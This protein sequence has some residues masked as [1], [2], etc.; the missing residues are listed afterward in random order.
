M[1]VVAYSQ[2]K[3]AA[4]TQLSD[5]DTI[6][7]VQKI[8]MLPDG[9]LIGGAGD[10]GEC[11]AYISWMK[12]SMSGEV[13]PDISPPKIKGAIL[14]RITPDGTIWFNEGTGFYPLLNK[15]KVAIGS[16]AAQAMALME[17][18]LS[19]EAAVRR[20]STLD[21]N[22]SQPIQVISLPS[23]LPRRKSSTP[24]AGRRSRAKKD[25]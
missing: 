17:E 11:W 15:D 7:R 24:S 19:A 23:A 6:Y 14:I 9:S 4:D 2:G 8:D 20:V 3:L 5:T 1:T 12:M 21:P 25:T 16:G 13:K 18:G 10:W 22:S